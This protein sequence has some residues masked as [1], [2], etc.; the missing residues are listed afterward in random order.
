MNKKQHHPYRKLFYC[1]L[2]ILSLSGCRKEKLVSDEQETFTRIYLEYSAYF[3]DAVELNDGNILAI[4]IENDTKLQNNKSLFTAKLDRSGN[5]ISKV[6]IT[7]KYTDG[8]YNYRICKLKNDD[9]WIYNLQTGEL[10]RIDENGNSEQQVVLFGFDLAGTIP[11]LTSKPVLGDDNLIYI[12]RSN[13]NSSSIYWYRIDLNGNVYVNYQVR[14]IFDPDPQRV[15]YQRFDVLQINGDTALVSV[16]WLPVTDDLKPD[17][18]SRHG[19]MKYKISPSGLEDDFSD[20]LLLTVDSFYRDEIDDVA[21]I[22]T[23]DQINYFCATGERR[24]KSVQELRYSYFRNFFDV[25][26]ATFDLKKEWTKRVKIEGFITNFTLRSMTILN[27]KSLII[28]AN[29]V[30]GTVS[31]PIFYRLDSKGELIYNN[32]NFPSNYNISTILALKD[33]KI[34]MLGNTKTAG[35]GKYMNTDHPL[36]IVSDPDL[37]SVY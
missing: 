31:R 36:V 22:Y 33:G 30:V 32:L 28:S 29:G 6:N 13:Y 18:S 24:V 34:M 21:Q 27:D 16:D 19:L 10:I 2:T 3:L 17:G 35:Q 8:G 7:P 4:G 11:W 37:N 26:K 9:L 12:T 25:S 14:S 20:A 1:F 5:I 23:S 15:N